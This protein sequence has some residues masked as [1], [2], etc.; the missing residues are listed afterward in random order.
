MNPPKLTEQAEVDLDDL[1]SRI[2]ADNPAEADRLVDAILEASRRHV[3][4]PGMGQRRDELRPG[5]R[6]FVV[7]PYVVFDRALDET[8]EVV[9][10]L[11][12][13]RDIPS[14]FESKP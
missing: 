1:W 11:H 13:A 2:A 3:R 7:S 10:V 5:V 9:R 4:F 6:C 14:V 12:G 8:I